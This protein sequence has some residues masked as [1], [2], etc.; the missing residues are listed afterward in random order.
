MD[1]TALSKKCFSVADLMIS[2]QGLRS[3]FEI[4]GVG[5]GSLLVT[6]YYGGR[7]ED[8]FSY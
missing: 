3:Y 2:Y 6:Q 1:V 4:G 8:T 7:G 5:W